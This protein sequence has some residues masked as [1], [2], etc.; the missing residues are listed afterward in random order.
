MIMI[1]GLTIS[2]FTGLHVAISLTAVGSGVAALLALS[3][4]TRPRWTIDLF[5]WTALTTTLTGFLFPFEGFTP[6]IG[7]G[8]FSLLPLTHAFLWRYRGNAPGRAAARF[9]ISAAVALWLNLFV[10]VVQAFLKIPVLNALAPAGTEAPFLIAQ[11]LALVTAAALGLAAWRK[12]R[13]P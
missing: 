7:V 13:Y 5:L 6:A 4:G 9:A 10:L 3:R 8:I 2:Q 12:A 11:G 1:A